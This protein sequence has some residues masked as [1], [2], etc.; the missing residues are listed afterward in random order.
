MI[1]WSEKCLSSCIVE[2]KQHLYKNYNFTK[3]KSR[4]Y[5]TYLYK[6]LRFSS[7]GIIKTFTKCGS[8]STT[9]DYK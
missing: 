2:I 4:N 1:L 3:I 8:A 5:Y 6:Y 7:G 9:F